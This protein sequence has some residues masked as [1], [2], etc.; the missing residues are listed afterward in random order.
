MKLK[1][2]GLKDDFDVVELFS[3][4]TED[5]QA[6]THE[7]AKLIKRDKKLLRL[8]KPRKVKSEKEDKDLLL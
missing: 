3:L 2:G 4:L 5:E 8:L 1:V 7:L 6:K